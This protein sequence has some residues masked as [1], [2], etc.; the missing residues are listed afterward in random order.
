MGVSVTR[1]PHVPGFTRSSD[2][3]GGVGVVM[4][5]LP[6]EDNWG[7]SPKAA[8]PKVTHGRKAL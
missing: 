6:D 3:P 4:F 8:Q 5:P 1:V 2:G 7:Q